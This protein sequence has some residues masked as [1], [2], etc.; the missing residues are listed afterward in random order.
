[1]SDHQDK[2]FWT[3]PLDTPS[4]RTAAPVTAVVFSPMV[5]CFPGD[6]IKQAHHPEAALGF[7]ALGLKQMLLV[8]LLCAEKLAPS[9]RISAVNTCR[10]DHLHK[11]MLELQLG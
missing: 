7:T 11:N 8:V 5:L 4:D 10:S 1:M 2:D 6:L 3:W 9:A